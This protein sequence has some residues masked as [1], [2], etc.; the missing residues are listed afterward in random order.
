MTTKIITHYNNGLL[1]NYKELKH[2]KMYKNSHGGSY[3]KYIYDKLDE[4]VCLEQSVSS[5]IA[6]KND[7]IIGCLLFFHSTAPFHNCYQDYNY[8]NIGT[9]GVYVK[10]ECRNSGVAKKLFKE[11]E[12]NFIELYSYSNDYI[13]VN[14]LEDAYPVAFKS[15]NWIIP[16][17]K[18]NSS[19][20]EQ[21]HLLYAIS[22]GKKTL[23]RYH[24]EKNKKNTLI[25]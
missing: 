5:L 18:E 15:F 22:N 4:G 10:K 13:L 23:K 3:F 8:I 1:K 7:K 25:T 19:Y 2:E 21:E 9:I 12:K 17:Q 24:Y 16:C 20:Q 6:Y 11:F 14:T